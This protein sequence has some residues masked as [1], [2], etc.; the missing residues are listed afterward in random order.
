MTSLAQTDKCGLHATPADFHKAIE[1]AARRGPDGKGGQQVARRQP[2]V[3][4]RLF[5]WAVNV[6]IDDAR[7]ASACSL[8][9]PQ[10]HHFGGGTLAS[11]TIPM[12]WGTPWSFPTGQLQC[13]SRPNDPGGQLDHP[14]H[15]S[16]SA[17]PRELVIRTPNSTKPFSTPNHYGPGY[18]G[19][20]DPRG[21]LL[22][23]T[24]AGCNPDPDFDDAWPG[25]QFNTSNCTYTG[26]YLDYNGMQINDPTNI[27]L[28]CSAGTGH[29][30]P[31]RTDVPI[32]Y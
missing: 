6:I 23:D 32:L 28:S 18:N 7:P 16:L 4:I 8:G 17:W 10:Q 30:G 19:Q 22:M 9:R 24:P 29:D 31:I 1:C 2:E 26:T 3:P 15:T 25:C 14:Y 12:R 11:S 5:P 13:A 27:L 20:N 21:D